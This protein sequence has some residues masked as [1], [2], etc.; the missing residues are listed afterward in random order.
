[1]LPVAAAE[2]DRAPEPVSRHARPA[3]DRRAAD[4]GATRR[5][6]VIGLV[7]V[8]GHGWQLVE[9]DDPHGGRWW[10]LHHHGAL[11]ATISRASTSRGRRG[12][13]AVLAGGFEVP[14][15]NALAAGAGSPLWRTR[16]LAVAGACHHHRTRPASPAHPPTPP[17]AG[18]APSP[19]PRSPDPG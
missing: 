18:L 16:D 9:Q 17:V 3:A 14:A 13:R 1:M 11:T 7:A 15:P 4:A 2:R 8:H 6:R 10:Q 5:T 12:W 19:S